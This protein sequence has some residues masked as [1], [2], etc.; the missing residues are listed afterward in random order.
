MKHRGLGRGDVG[1]GDVGG[2]RTWGAGAGALLLGGRNSPIPHRG[3]HDPCSPI[4]HWRWDRDDPAGFGSPVVRKKAHWCSLKSPS[5]KA[6]QPFIF[7]TGMI[8]E[9]GRA[10]LVLR[11]DGPDD[12]GAG[13]ASGAEVREQHEVVELFREEEGMLGFWAKTSGGEILEVRAR[14]PSMPA[15]ARPLYTRNAWRRGS[16][17]TRWR[18]TYYEGRFGI[19][20]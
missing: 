18:W 16:K 11:S 2:L 15:D 8:G 9:N 6:S 4:R 3:V 20:H 19:G 17:P 13:P 10:I 7:Q 14:S 1:G 5:G 12:D